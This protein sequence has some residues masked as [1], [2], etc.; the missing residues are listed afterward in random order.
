MKGV[1]VNCRGGTMAMHIIHKHKLTKSV[2]L[3]HE[4]IKNSSIEIV[5]Y[6]IIKKMLCFYCM[7]G[8]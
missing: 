4:S 5:L 8:G 1:A 2:Q 7:L 6:F 3:N